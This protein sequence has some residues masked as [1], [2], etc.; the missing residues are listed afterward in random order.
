MRSLILLGL[1]TLLISPSAVLIASPSVQ[2]A[3]DVPALTV[4]YGSPTTFGTH[5]DFASDNFAWGPS[6]GQF[7]VIAQG[8]GTYTFYGSAASATTCT[9]PPSKALEGEFAYT[10]TLDHITGGNGCN[11]LFRPGDG[12][13]GWVFDRDYAGSGDVYPFTDGNTKGYLLPFH[14]EVHWQNPATA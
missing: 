1:I 8:N 3:T 2:S 12:P 14:A 9:Q 5:D 6:D 13:S 10:G 11:S 4:A 7:G